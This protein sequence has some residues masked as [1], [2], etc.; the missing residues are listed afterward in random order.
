MGVCIRDPCLP[1]LN[2]TLCQR[3]D[4]SL[5]A[6]VGMADVKARWDPRSERLVEGSG[7][8][9]CGTE[10]VLRQIA[11]GPDDVPYRLRLR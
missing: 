3:H 8:L 11:R 4:C 6:G 2:A 5:P 1:I 7:A 9:R 10:C